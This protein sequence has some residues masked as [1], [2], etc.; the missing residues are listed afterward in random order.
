[1]FPFQIKKGEILE[2]AIRIRFINTHWIFRNRTTDCPGILIAARPEQF[3][4]LCGQPHSARIL[5]WYKQIYTQKIYQNISDAMI[6]MGS[7]SKVAAWKPQTCFWTFLNIVQHCSTS[8]TGMSWHCWQGQEIH[9]VT[10]DEFQLHC[11]WLPQLHRQI[12]GQGMRIRFA[13]PPCWAWFILVYLDWYGW[14]ENIRQM[15]RQ[16][17]SM[18]GHGEVMG[19][20]FSPEK[21]ETT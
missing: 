1:M 19:L 12:S 4:A 9:P 16:D 13:W 21:K 18:L 5:Q 20:I 8:K 6:G 11:T 17:M 3:L 10:S 14:K 2:A 15:E 7:E